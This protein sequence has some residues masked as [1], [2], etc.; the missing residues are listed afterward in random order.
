MYSVIWVMFKAHPDRSFVKITINN[1]TYKAWPYQQPGIYCAY[2]VENLKLPLIIECQDWC[3]P[4]MQIDCTTAHIN[5]V[6]NQMRSDIDV[7]KIDLPN[8]TNQLADYV[9]TKNIT[10]VPVLVGLQKDKSF[11]QSH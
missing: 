8:S 7:E 3:K 6:W 11:P 9:V 1:K 10:A 2:M 4:F 5:N